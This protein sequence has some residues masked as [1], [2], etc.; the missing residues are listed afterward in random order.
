LCPCFF[1][2]IIRRPPRSTLFPYT[3]LFRSVVDDVWRDQDQE[4]AP[5]LRLRREAEQLP[6]ER[7]VYKEGD[8]RLGYRDRGHREAAD[9]RRLAVVD[10]YLV[11]GLLRLER[12]ADVHRRGLDA[13]VL[14]VHLHEHLAVGRHVWR[15]LEVDPRLL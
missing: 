7:Q 10:E 14:G 2:S 13:R 11:V 1:F 9:H 12:E 6:E 8:S 4:I 15:H 3:T 5:L